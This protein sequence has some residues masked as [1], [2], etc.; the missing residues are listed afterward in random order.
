MEAPSSHEGFLFEGFLLD[1]RGLFRCDEDATQAPVE[2]GSRALDVL[3]VL[4]KR[5]GDLVSRDEIM[6][7]AWP[8]TVVEDNNLTVQIS[9]LRRVLDQDRAQGSCIQTVPGRGYRFVVPVTRLESATS[10]GSELSFGDG[11]GGPTAGNGRSRDPVALGQLAN[12]LQLQ[13]PRMGPRFRRGVMAPALGALAL[14]VAVVVGIWYSPWLEHAHRAPRL[15]I[16]VMPFANLSDD[17]E[18]QYFAD[19]ITDDVTNDLSRIAGMFVISRNTAFTYQNKP[20]DP[21]EIGRELGVRYVL[22][23]SARRLGKQVRVNVQLIDAE[24]DSHIW[25]ER[26][27]HDTNDLVALQSEITDQIAVALDA[28]VTSAEA[29]RSREHPDALEYILRGRAALSK[30]SSPA[31][32]AQ[33]IPLY[34]HALQLDPNSVTAKSWLATTLMSRMFDAMAD[35]PETDIARAKELAEEAVASSPR[36]PLAHFAKGMVLRAQGRDA[37]AIPEYEAVIAFNP[38]WVPAITALSWCKF[39]TGS[40]EEGIPM[41]ER[42]LRLSPRDPAIDAWYWRIGMVQL[43]QSHTDEAI[44]WLERARS[45][46]PAR[47]SPHAWLASAYALKGEADRAANELAEARRLVHGNLYSSITRMKAILHFG[48]PKMR[49]LY[50]ATFLTGLRQAGVPEE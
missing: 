47:P 18:Q 28:E 34:E 38:N 4:L 36:S 1:R 24:T 17:R 27:D 26:F 3:G 48:V 8:G 12:I 33:A 16:V 23:G 31:N 20:I 10:R 21:K 49:A 14:I 19:G 41:Q 42:A 32:Y 22:E 35:S 25:A 5:P 9:T 6:A 11:N 50:E 44:M 15:S 29:A 2:I 46:N 13:T 45:A 37:E 7:T 40:L 43:L 39:M 30:P